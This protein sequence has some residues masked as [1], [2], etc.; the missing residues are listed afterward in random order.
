MARLYMRTT[1]AMLT[2][3]HPIEMAMSTQ[4]DSKWEV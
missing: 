4:I 3:E 1:F 2:I